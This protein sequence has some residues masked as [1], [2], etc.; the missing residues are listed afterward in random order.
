[1]KEGSNMFKVDEGFFYVS[2]H[3]DGYCVVDAVP[4]VPFEVHAKE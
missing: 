3:G 4:F 2:G 1:M